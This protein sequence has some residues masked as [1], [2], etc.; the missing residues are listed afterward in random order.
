[1]IVHMLRG[2]TPAQALDAALA[3]ADLPGGLC[4]AARGA[5]SRKRSELPNSGWVRHTLES[6][7]WA[8]LTTHS[9]EEAV[10]QAANLGSD[11]DTSACVAGALA[12]A[13]YGLSGIPQRW[14]EKMRG[15]YPLGSGQYWAEAE[16]TRL[17][18]RLAG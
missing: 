18:S 3:A 5:A 7:L 15:E 8:L 14:R 4:Q 1:M 10:V 17:A 13:Y 11:A 16:L 12:G 9:F 6:A 2:R